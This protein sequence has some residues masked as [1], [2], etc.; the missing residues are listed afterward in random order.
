MEDET[1][2]IIFYI[3]NIISTYTI[4]NLIKTLR[5]LLVIIGFLKIDLL[6]GYNRSRLL[7]QIDVGWVDEKERKGK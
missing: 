5:N 6:S 7:Y 4:K 1:K 3:K 2:I